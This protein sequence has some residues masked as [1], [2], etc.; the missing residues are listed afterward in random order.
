MTQENE[1]Q[2]IEQGNAAEELINNQ[3]FNDTFA[4]VQN[5]AIQHWMSS[6]PEEAEQRNT[7]YYLIRGLNDMAAVLKQQM[8][9]RDQILDKNEA[10]VVDHE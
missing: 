7:A 8:Q 4:I 10:G 2:L 9:I 6:K 3:A 1:Q 5:G